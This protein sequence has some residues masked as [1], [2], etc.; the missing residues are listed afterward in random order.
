MCGYQVFILLFYSVTRCSGCAST[1]LNNY[2]QQYKIE[3]LN[4]DINRL[5]RFAD[6]HK[7]IPGP[8]IIILSLTKKMAKTIHFH[9][10]N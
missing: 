4:A 7:I 9:K 1:I 6:E 8:K 3:K 10:K 2:F 5:Y